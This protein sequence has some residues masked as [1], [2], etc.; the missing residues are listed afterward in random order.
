MDGNDAQLGTGIWGVTDHVRGTTSRLIQRRPKNGRI[1][2]LL[3]TC[4]L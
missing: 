1:Y 2:R 4:F 3:L